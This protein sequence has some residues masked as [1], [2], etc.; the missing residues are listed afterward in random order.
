MSDPT[1]I[2][3]ILGLS[4]DKG[5]PVGS[6]QWELARYAFHSHYARSWA[7]DAG[8]ASPLPPADVPELVK[9]AILCRTFGWSPS[10]AI[11]ALNVDNAE[12]TTRV[13]TVISVFDAVGEL[14]AVNAYNARLRDECIDRGEFLR[15][16]DMRTVDDPAVF[17][18]LND[19]FEVGRAMTD[20][21]TATLGIRED[22]PNE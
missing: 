12:L 8:A 3:N 15:A 7:N 19:L 20:D 13:A 16:K 17:A 10:E 1:N 5:A 11:N 14:D 6:W 21:E 9:I 22:T 4:I 18:L 2:V